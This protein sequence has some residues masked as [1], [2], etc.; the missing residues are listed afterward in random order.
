MIGPH[1]N[2][3]SWYGS[4]FDRATAWLDRVPGGTVRGRLARVAALLL[5]VA[6]LMAARLDAAPFGA[7]AAVWADRLIVTVPLLCLLGL[8][9]ALVLARR[10][11]GLTV[12]ERS[13]G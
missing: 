8:W 4:A 13:N 1:P 6:G 9:E 12:P 7:T 5:A 2:G 11:V 10:M 3:T